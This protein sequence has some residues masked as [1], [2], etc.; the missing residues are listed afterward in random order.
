MN[1][2]FPASWPLACGCVRLLLLPPQDDK[3]MSAATSWTSA[4]VLC[5]HR[6]TPHF[7]F[8]A[9]FFVN[10]SINLLHQNEYFNPN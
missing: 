6:A 4:A 2:Q 9:R 1:C 10:R 8:R 7:P 5:R 3:A